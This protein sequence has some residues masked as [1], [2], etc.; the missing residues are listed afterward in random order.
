MIDTDIC[1]CKF[2]RDFPPPEEITHGREPTFYYLSKEQ[3]KLGLKVHVICTLRHRSKEYENLD[4]INVHRVS[5]PYTFHAL[6]MFR[7][8]SKDSKMN[9]V[10]DHAT[11]GMGYALLKRIVGPKPLVV[12]VHHIRRGSKG[13]PL[14]YSLINSLKSRFWTYRSLIQQR[15]VWKRADKVIAVSKAVANDVMEFYKIDSDKVHVVYNGVDPDIFR[16]H[17]DTEE[18]ARKLEVEGKKVVLFV[19]DFGLRKGLKYLIQA[20]PSV[21]R[22]IPDAMFILIGGT[23]KW[24]GTSIYWRMLHEQIQRRHVQNYVKLMGEVEHLKLLKYY[25]LADVFILPS[26][27][28]GFGKVILEAMASTRPVVA[29]NVGGIPE[30]ITDN[31]DGL[32]IPPCRSEEI[33]RALISLLS[34]PKRSRRMGLRG[35]RKVLREFTWSRAAKKTNNVYRLLMK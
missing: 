26:L 1:V 10:H 32:L 7:K 35:R 20:V 6:K 30:I 24:L 13:I 9:V 11:S 23:P 29:T 2:I 31:V 14:S 12:H 18:I 27:Y 34:D 3:A 28:E 16:P 8:L 22:E 21:I 15:L 19:G 4:G 33:A 25:S 17:E 5:S